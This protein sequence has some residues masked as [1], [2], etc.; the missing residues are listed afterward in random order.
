MVAGTPD[1]IPLAPY[2]EIRKNARVVTLDWTVWN[3]VKQIRSRITFAD[4]VTGT[5]YLAPGSSSET[6]GPVTS[7]PA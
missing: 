7:R 1:A 4:P 2:A 6:H 5:R 3:D